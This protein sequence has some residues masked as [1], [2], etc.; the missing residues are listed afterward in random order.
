MMSEKKQGELEGFE[1]ESIPELDKHCATV[2]KAIEKKRLATDK[3]KQENANLDA[4]MRE[5]RAAGR[6]EQSGDKEHMYLFMD[7]DLQ[8][9]CFIRDESVV[10]FRNHKQAKAEGADLKVHEGGKGDID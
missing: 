5:M 6:L 8:R 7:G 3:L 4:R 9:E 10:G 2:T 1:R